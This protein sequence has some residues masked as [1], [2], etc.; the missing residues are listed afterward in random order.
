M[1]EPKAARVCAAAPDAAAQNAARLAAPGAA[2]AQ[3]AARLAALDAAAAQNAARLAALDALCAA[4]CAE[5]T[6]L[7]AKMAVLRAQGKHKSCQFREAMGQ[8]LSNS[9]VISRLQ[10][11][12]L[13][14]EPAAKP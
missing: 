13:W 11:C 3:N 14:S 1:A 5:Q 9:L 2:A 12:G 8:K 6:A 7:R 10:S 4:L